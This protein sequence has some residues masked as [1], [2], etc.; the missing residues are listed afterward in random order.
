MNSFGTG[1]ANAFKVDYA[2]TSGTAIDVAAG[3]TTGLARDVDYFEAV[4]DAD[5]LFYSLVGGNWTVSKV[6]T[7]P[8]NGAGA[9][10]R[11]IFL[12]TD[13]EDFAFDVI[14]RVDNVGVPEPLR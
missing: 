3:R 4:F 11:Y 9:N 7:G 1:Q 6:S 10:A 2:Y 13:P 14:I 12:K 5:A 8:F